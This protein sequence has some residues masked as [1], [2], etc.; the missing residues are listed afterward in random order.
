[1]VKTKTSIDQTSL[2]ASNQTPYLDIDSEKDELSE[3]QILKGKAVVM[4][5][6]LTGK[7][8]GASDFFLKQQADATSTIAT[9]V[10]DVYTTILDTTL[11]ARIL[12]MIAQITWAV[13]QPTNL[14]IRLTIDGQILIFGVA[15]PVTGT[16]YLAQIRPNQNE[17]NQ[18]LAGLADI[19]NFLIEGSSIKIEAAVTWAVTQPTN[20]IV[21]VKYAKR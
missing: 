1:M 7:A 17:A 16:N 13:T 19:Q 21:R 12:C 9:P 14:R 11:N 8:L 5:D 15:S 10:S 18:I 2:N 3:A 4:I 20:L 6:P